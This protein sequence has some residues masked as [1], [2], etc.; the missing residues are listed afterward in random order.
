MTEGHESARERAESIDALYS[1]VA[2]LIRMDRELDAMRLLVFRHGWSAEIS[3]AI[4][5]VEGKLWDA[6][7]RLDSTV[8]AVGWMRYLEEYDARVA[9]RSE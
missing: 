6:I 7:N 8:R 2:R 3:R 4:Y 9:K 5:E 1:T